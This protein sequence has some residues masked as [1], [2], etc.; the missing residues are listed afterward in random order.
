MTR[1]AVPLLLSLCA[2]L[3]LASTGCQ[4]IFEALQ[5][6]V[7]QA[8]L[9]TWLTDW[10]EDHDMVAE[11]IHCPGDQP[12]EQ[13]HSFECTCKVHGTDIP[14]SVTVTDAANGVVEWEP[15]YLTVPRSAVEQEIM[16]KPELAGHDLAIDCHDPV[17]ISIP[18]SEWKCEITDNGDGGKKF[19]ATILFV[20]DEGTHK[21]SIEPA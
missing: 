19:V 5:P 16:D 14:V 10:L 9:E 15:K 11:D 1:R 13:D 7:T 21:M 3:T 8:E 18:D 12:L 20:D 2:S 17:W 4:K 6:K